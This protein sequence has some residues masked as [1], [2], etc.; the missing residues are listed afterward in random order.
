VPS[1][2]WLPAPPTLSLA[3][4]EVHVWRAD[5][6]R[7]EIAARASSLSPE[8]QQRAANMRLEETQRH[9]RAGR[10]MMRDLLGRY[11]GA[12]ADAI[13]FRYG[14]QG[15]PELS[16]PPGA[17]LHFNLAH[18]AGRAVFAVTRAAPL[19]VDLEPVRSLSDFDRL[20]RRIFRP[21]EHREW[22]AQ[23]ESL[24][25]ATFFAG[26]TRKE[27]FIKAIG[28][29]LSFP[30]RSFEVALRPDEPPRLL[31]APAAEPTAAAWT[32]LDLK[33]G[34]DFA[35]ALVVAAPGPLAFSCWEYD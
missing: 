5:L 26:W 11:S 30:L 20:A 31:A 13:H 35:G 32:W 27:A 10:A 14:V 18:A 6:D 4:G 24:R 25:P 22:L 1:C 23:A 21:G 19:G 33:L 3:A 34:P 2:R 9:F 28:Q 15:K 16:H 17:G 8:E 29:G 7:P 12:A